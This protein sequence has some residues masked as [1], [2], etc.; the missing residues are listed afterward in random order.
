[1]AFL[2]M[3]D[4]SCRLENV[5][6]FSEGWLKFKKHFKQGAVLLL[7]GSRQ[8]KRNSFLIN[9]VHKIKNIA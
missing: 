7:R 2:S 4:S 3:S 1:M 5:V 6:I 8:K 9:S